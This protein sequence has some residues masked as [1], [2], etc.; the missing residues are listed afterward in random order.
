MSGGMRPDP[1]RAVPPRPAAALT[2]AVAR[3]GRHDC[4]SA[5]PRYHSSSTHSKRQRNQSPGKRP[6]HVSRATHSLGGEGSS[7][8]PEAGK[9]TT[10]I[11]KG[12]KAM[13]IPELFTTSDPPITW[14]VRTSFR[15]SMHSIYSIA[16]CRAGWVPCRPHRGAIVAR[17]PSLHSSAARFVPRAAHNRPPSSVEATNGEMINENPDR[18]AI[19]VRMEVRNQDQW[20]MDC[21]GGHAIPVKPSDQTPGHNI[22]KIHPGVVYRC[23]GSSISRVKSSKG[24]QELTEANRH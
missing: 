16:R 18:P 3:D 12:G 20:C 19:E 24:S 4:S 1:P 17:D 21:M 11:R 23:T 6:P 8:L 5:S 2:V 10:V 22:R 9:C 15:V 14:S 7:L 13:L